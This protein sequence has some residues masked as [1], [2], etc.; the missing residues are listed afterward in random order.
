MDKGFK[1]INTKIKTPKSV[2][3]DV[4]WHVEK[5]F[6]VE[7]I[8]KHFTITFGKSLISLFNNKQK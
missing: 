8:F 2:K 3:D 7:A 1:N 4:M 6:L 5:V